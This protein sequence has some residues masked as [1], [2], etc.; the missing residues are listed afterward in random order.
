MPDYLSPSACH[1]ILL[2]ETRPALAYDGGPVSAWQR[3]LRP[4]L[5]R[6]SGLDRMPRAG[7]RP[8]L[9]VR[10][11]WRRRHALGW[12][13]KLTFIAERAAEVPAYFCTPHEA[14]P[15]YAVAICLQG[16]TSGMHNSIGVAAEDEETPIPAEGDR[17]FANG[18]LRR[19][20]AALCL[21]QRSLGERAERVQP[22]RSYYNACHDAAMRALLLGRTLLAERVYD[23]DRGL[24]YLAT[25]ADVDLDRVGIVGNSGGGT[26]AIWAGAL[27]PRVRFLMPGCSFCGVAG[28]IAT[29]H[30]CADNYVPGL[31]TIADLPDVLG[32]FAPRPVIVIAGKDDPLFPIAEVKRAFTKLRSIYRAANAGDRAKLVIGPEG[33]RF[34]ADLGWR[35]ARGL[36]V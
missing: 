6:L 5:R 8:P 34:Y 15:P 25:R 9:D 4:A 11:H 16:H 19:G 21:E 18:C 13:E 3:R 14:R 23:V 1:R 36:F 22:R 33:H 7:A 2:D 31:L 10:T 24:D 26:V 20:I 12:I 17:D 27:L 29:V 32:L 35:A 30:H 28:S